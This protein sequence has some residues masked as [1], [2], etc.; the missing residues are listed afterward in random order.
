MLK[1]A[2]TIG[3]LTALFLA[4][5]PN[6]SAFAENTTRYWSNNPTVGFCSNVS[7]GIVAAAQAAV[8]VKNGNNTNTVDGQFGTVSYNSVFAFQQS[9]GLSADGCVGPQTWAALQSGLYRTCCANDTHHSND[10]LPGPGGVF[11]N[12]DFSHYGAAC[13][14]AY[15]YEQGAPEPP[16]GGSILPYH[17]Y[18]FLGGGSFAQIYPTAS[19]LQCL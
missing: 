14:W 12:F 10:T 19:N 13:Y 18:R 6:S 11:A 1:R 5:I 9:H 2:T 17:F 3:L 7:G 8:F 4:L 15:A 16:A